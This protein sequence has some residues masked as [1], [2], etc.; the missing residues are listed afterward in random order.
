M[1]IPTANV[2]AQVFRCP[3]CGAPMQA[4]S[5]DILAVGCASCGAVVDTADLNYTLLSKA[6]G[7]RDEQYQPRLALGSKGT[8]EGKP[9][10]VIGFLVKQC[11]VDGI[12]YDWREYLLAGELGSYRWLTEYNGHWNIADVLSNPP[13]SSG[14]MELS[15]VR[16]S[17]QVFKHFATTPAAEVIQV[18]GEFTWRVRR[19]ETTG[20]GLCRA[21]ADVVARG[22]VRPDLVA[23]AIC[24][25]GRDRRGL[26]VCRMAACQTDRVLCNQP[27]PWEATN[28]RVCSCSGKWPCLPCCCRSSSSS[29]RAAKLLCARISPFRRSGRGLAGHPRLRCA[30]SRARSRAQHDDARQ[31]LDRPRPHAGHKRPV[32]PGRPHA[33]WLLPR[34]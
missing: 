1:P 20:G 13:G 6:L 16:W 9:A 17:G 14:A 23:G 19:G 27:N 32:P 22:D 4:R 34:L 31:Q 12:A 29:C 33:N 25:A 26:Q 21:A 30:T 18:A 5:K 2:A 10:E 11:K 8:L 7:P 3:S 24:R 15:E 28:Q